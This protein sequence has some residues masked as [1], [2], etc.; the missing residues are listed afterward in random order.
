M[1]LNKFQLQEGSSLIKKS[2]KVE[3]PTILKESKITNDS[4]VEDK[5]DKHQQKGKT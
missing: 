3:T 4:G 1:Q 5:F 2:D